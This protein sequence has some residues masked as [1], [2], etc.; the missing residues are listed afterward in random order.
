MGEMIMKRYVVNLEKEEKEHLEQLTS[1]GSTETFFAV[2]AKPNERLISVGSASSMDYIA[3][4]GFEGALNH[5]R[6]KAHLWKNHLHSSGSP[7][8]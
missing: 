8:K 5:K 6:E 2:K 1:K 3:D 7:C 4:K